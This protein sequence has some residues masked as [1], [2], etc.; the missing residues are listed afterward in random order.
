VHLPAITPTDFVYV[1][2][3]FS[4]LG[5]CCVA[6]VVWPPLCGRRC[7]ATVVSLTYLG[8]DVV[9]MNMG[10][11]LVQAVV[12]SHFFSK[13]NCMVSRDGRAVP[14]DTLESINQLG[15]S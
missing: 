11:L 3:R 7:V 4:E 1:R 2:K 6:T 15:F 12:S 5:L 9:L 10:S 8:A 13:M 14:C